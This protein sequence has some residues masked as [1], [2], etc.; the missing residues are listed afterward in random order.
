[1]GKIHWGSLAL[2]A[3]LGVVLYMF[4]A[5]RRVSSS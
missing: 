2:G 1:M 5:R 4:F 3:V